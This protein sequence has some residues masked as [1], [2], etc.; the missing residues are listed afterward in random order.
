M[1]TKRK[2]SK[3]RM[4]GEILRNSKLQFLGQEIPL[5]H[6]ST[7]AGDPGRNMPPGEGVFRRE[8]GRDHSRL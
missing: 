5:I 1:D 4:G 6:S 2:E 8:K 3:A 7:P